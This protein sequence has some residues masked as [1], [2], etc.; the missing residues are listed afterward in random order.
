MANDAQKIFDL[1]LEEFPCRRADKNPPWK[2]IYFADEK[3][4][5]SSF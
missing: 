1:S 4:D 5:P 2:Q 3:A